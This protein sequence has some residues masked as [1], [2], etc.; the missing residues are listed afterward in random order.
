M[1]DVRRQP[2]P[3]VSDQGVS[4]NNRIAV[5]KAKNRPATKVR[6]ACLSENL[7]PSASVSSRARETAETGIATNSAANIMIPNWRNLLSTV[8]YIERQNVRLP[9]TR[10][11]APAVSTAASP[12]V[13]SLSRSIKKWVAPR[14]IVSITIDA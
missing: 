14:N 1:S 12:V 9:A 2:T 10:N 3:A 8:E 5:A 4:I 13:E 11:P 6:A 7:S